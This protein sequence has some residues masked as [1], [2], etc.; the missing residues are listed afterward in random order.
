MSRKD[1]R[2]GDTGV[3]ISNLASMIRTWMI[4]AI[5]RTDSW[6]TVA[7]ENQERTDWRMLSVPLI[8][9]GP[10]LR[11]RRWLRED[12]RMHKILL[13]ADLLGSGVRHGVSHPGSGRLSCLTRP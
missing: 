3:I 7:T 11:G 13:N 1:D 6:N 10:M 8:A 5:Q 9:D 2:L 12:D 4:E